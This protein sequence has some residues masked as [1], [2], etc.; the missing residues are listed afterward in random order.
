MGEDHDDATLVIQGK[1]TR[2]FLSAT[3]FVCRCSVVRCL[4]F[5]IVHCVPFFRSPVQP[6]RVA[7]VP[8]P[9]P[10]RVVFPLDPEWPD[11]T[12]CFNG[13]FDSR[14]RRI[15]YCLMPPAPVDIEEGSGFG[16]AQRQL[17]FDSPL[18]MQKCNA[19]CRFGIV[20]HNYMYGVIYDDYL[21]NRLYVSCAESDLA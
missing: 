14:T 5:L 11:W 21:C 16:D 4:P 15:R 12:L 13:C 18:P 1:S 19:S 10:V 3:I 20:M 8:I 2:S 7:S 6:S 9:I 17:C